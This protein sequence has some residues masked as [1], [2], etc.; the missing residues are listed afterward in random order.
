ML[1]FY[2]VKLHSNY[3]ISFYLFPICRLYSRNGDEDTSE[4]TDEKS[5]TIDNCIKN[6]LRKC[7]FVDG[8]YYD[9]T[10]PYFCGQDDRCM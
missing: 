4:Y 6:K 9:L 1:L 8:K 2:H 5:I 3:V 10:I 7:T